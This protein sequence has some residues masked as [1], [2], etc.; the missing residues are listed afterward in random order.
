MDSDAQPIIIKK[1]KAA[2]HGHHG[3]AWKVAYA[4][5]VTAMM[6]LFIVLWLLNTSDN[7]KQAISGYFATGSGNG[8]LAGSGLSG[9]GEGLAL[10]KQDMS[11]LKEK[12]E[13]ALKAMP[14]FDALK[15]NVEM[16]VTGEG[17]RLEL[18]ET[19]KGM[20]FESGNA[21]PTGQGSELLEKLAQELGKLKNPIVIEGHTDAR[22]FSSTQHYSNWELSVDRANAARRTLQQFGIRPDQVKQVRGYAD[23]HLR[24]PADPADAANRRVTVIVQYQAPAAPAASGPPPAANH[25]S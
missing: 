2:H 7:V 1:K 17:L 9:E 8:K 23:Q 6:A 16:T 12:I 13:G 11:Q 21:V 20:F 22:P 15:N 4:D 24:N 19:E 18:L 25:H 10:G 5:F 3:G 14:K